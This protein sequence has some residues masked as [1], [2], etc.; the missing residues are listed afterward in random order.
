MN[1]CQ[2]LQVHEKPGMMGG[3]ITK[4]AEEEDP[5]YKASQGT[6][7]EFVSKNYKPGTGGKCI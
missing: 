4:E 1:K 6:Y 5:D 7:Q 2:T 3:T